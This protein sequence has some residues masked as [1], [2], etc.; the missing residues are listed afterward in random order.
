M[1]SAGR[2]LQPSGYNAIH[3][4]RPPAEQEATS[5]QCGSLS[6]LY[7]YGFVQQWLLFYWALRSTKTGGLCCCVIQCMLPQVQ[8]RCCCCCCC[9]CFCYCYCCSAIVVGGRVWSRVPAPSSV[10][11]FPCSSVKYFPT[12]AVLLCSVCHAC[13]CRLSRVCALC[14]ARSASKP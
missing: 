10:H 2:V 4:C 1:S 12:T 14:H 13:V 11:P 5:H 3:A 8:Q 7:C 6:E 9:Y